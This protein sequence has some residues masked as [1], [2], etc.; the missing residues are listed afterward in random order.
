MNFKKFL[1]FLVKYKLIKIFINL[2][3]LISI[4]IIFSKTITDLNSLFNFFDFTIISSIIIVSIVNIIIISIEK[5][6]LN[7]VEDSLK[8]T[9]N[10]NKLISNYVF[11]NEYEW[12]NPNPSNVDQSLPML[13]VYKTDKLVVFPEI[14]T[15]NLYHKQIE[16]IDNTNIYI[17]PKFVLDNY[18]EIMQS[19]LTS[20]IYNQLNIRV[21]DWYFDESKQKFIIK[22]SRTN[23]F[24]S[25]VTNRA[26]DYKLSNGFTVR[27]LY[28]Y[29]PFVN[30]LNKSSLS[31]HLGFNGIIETSDNMILF[32]KRNKHLSTGKNVYGTSIAASLKCKYAINNNTF[33]LNGLKS[34]ILNEIYDECKINCSDS[35]F[36]LEENL[37]AAYRDLVEGGKPQLV[38]YVHLNNFTKDQLRM[39]FQSFTKK[40]KNKK[41]STLED[42]H[43][44]LWIPKYDLNNITF[45]QDYFKYKNKKYYTTPSMLVSFI[46]YI[47][48]INEIS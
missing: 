48:H 4:F 17:P 13:I 29:G 41:H 30:P 6:I 12:K 37:I 27:S 2:L 35:E 22:T 31:N 42:G 43:K 45:G 1:K 44:F 24:N 47:K 8:I 36:K 5:F 14:I 26:M 34:A 10:Y 16:I 39:N 33:T 15:C 38:F 11:K 20:D 9:T 25:L 7:N 18:F 40:K 23:Y 28:D 19:H 3:V 21:D 46:L 32:I